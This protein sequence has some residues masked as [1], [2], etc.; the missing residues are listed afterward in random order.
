MYFCFKLEHRGED[1]DQ[2][3]KAKIDHH[4]P[5]VQYACVETD[6]EATLYLVQNCERKKEEPVEEKKEV[7]K[8]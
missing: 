8:E 3:F 2:D 4:H 7:A 5:V 6:G 1:P